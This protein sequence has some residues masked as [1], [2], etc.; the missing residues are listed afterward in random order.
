[1][2]S[3]EA[4]QAASDALDK[5]LSQKQMN[6]E[7]IRSLGPAIIEALKP[8]LAE[9]ATN[10]KVTREELVAAI[11][12]IKITV[13]KADVPQAEVKVTIPDIKVPQ[14][15]VNVTVP[16][17]KIPE[18]KI[19]K[20][21][22]P[23][24]EVTVTVP[25]LK[26]PTERMPIEGWVNLMGVDLQ[27]PLPVRVMN[28]KDFGGQVAALMGGGGGIVTIGGALATVGVVTINPDGT[29]TYTTSAAGSSSSVYLTNGDGVYY[30]SANP[31]PVSATFS[32]ST[33]VTITNYDGLAYNSD[34][35]LPVTFSAASIQPVSQVSGHSWSVFASFD[36]TATLYNADNRLRVSVETGGSGLTDSELRASHLD[37][38]QM[39]GTAD[40]V[41]VITVS[42]IFSTTVA[43]TVVNADNRVKVEL[44]ATTV[45]VGNA[46]IPVTE[47]GSW[48][49]QVQDSQ[50]STI[51]SHQ[52]NTDF[53]GLDVYI[54]GSLNTTVSELANGDNRLKVDGSATTQPISITDIFAT[55]VT[56]NV[57]N[58]DN[59]VKVE[60]P[61]TTV[62]VA[63]I[64]A[65]TAA[66]LVDSS[67]VQYSGSNP[68]P[69]S[70]T[71]TSATV[72]VQDSFASTIT[73]HVS[74]DFR[75][76]DHYILGAAASTY[77]ELLNA[78][79]RVKVELPATTVTVQDA[80]TTTS[81]SSIVNADNRIKVELPAT[82]VT[83][84]Q[85]GSWAVQ[86][87]DS[88]ASTISSHIFNTDFRGLDVY[89]GGS[90][91]TTV[92]EIT[93]G[94]N[95][96]KVDGSATTQ[97]ISVTDIFATTATSN[98][99]D[100]DNRVKVD[101]AMI[102]GLNET[103]AG[104][105]RTVQ[106]TDSVSSVNV[107]NASLAITSANTLEVKQLS[108]SSDSVAATQVG[109][110]NVTVQ[111]AQAS[112]FSAFTIGDYK[113]FPTVILD[114]SGAQITSFGGGTQYSIDNNAGAIGIGTV[115]LGVRTST[116]ASVVSADLD[117]AP[118]QLDANG[119]MWATLGTKLDPV[120]DSITTYAAADSV[121]SVQTKFIARQT[122]P[123]AVADAA[124]SFGSSDDLGRQITRPVNA[125]DLTQT[126]YVSV[127]NGT[128]TTL[129]AAG[130]AGVFYD[131]IFL[132]FSNN[133]TVAV[134]VDV[135]TVTAGNV[136]MH[137]E[138][139]ANGVVGG[140]LP[141][142][143]PQSNANNNW[144]IDLPDITGTTVTVSGLFSKEI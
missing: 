12:G 64:T 40:S 30:N 41:N 115:A 84:T 22:V 87:Q 111:D 5:A 17:I 45:T 62:T 117:W 135:R 132:Q 136:E 7:L 76:L 98:V 8:V 47:S 37:V 105:L 97:P 65:T 88:Q 70:T 52:F 130:G 119:N 104:V 73:S 99:V 20:I 25:D 83:T 122:N 126:A 58:T 125:R 59:R 63:S 129:L 110:W 80:L 96:L 91:N 6:Q 68:L 57:V 133:S 92:S 67:G 48:S 75:G 4:L 24:A 72:Q 86:V 143:W 34:N 23:K 113:S 81:A 27:N 2:T 71:I 26:W 14:P 36:T 109:T 28:A 102:A 18:I 21:T 78:D 123:T 15:Q 103:N 144:T 79:G 43:S 31:L 89:I 116:A 77:S 121:Q 140:A 94:D 107:V 142:P 9:V 46:S 108:G 3:E 56:S 118:T 141:V 50:A 61:A 16:P 35:P 120:N 11:S 39:S 101:V 33:T 95:R 69:T 60:L 32:G 38:V 93:N 112:S 137:Y 82:T 85:S 54:G 19:P 106:M 139:P 13:P 114:G 1:M 124:A 128:E 53:R 127:A 51:S 29:P 49:V 134:G 44:P 55:T 66:S 100:P 10:S 131:L 42:D 74:G 138:V 90:L